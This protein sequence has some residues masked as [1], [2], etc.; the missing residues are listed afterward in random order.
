MSGQIVFG[1]NLTYLHTVP[2]GSIDLIYIDP[3]FNTGHKQV[4]KQLRTVRD[5]KTPD[6]KGFKGR[7]YRTEVLGQQEFSDE[8][9]DFMG[10]IMPRLNEAHRVLK[11][12]GSLF[13]HLDY[14]ESTLLRDLS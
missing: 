4:R 10:F 5:D 7:G 12:T 11:P 14:R 2:D 1:D 13:L 3:P 8:F 6:R 9:G